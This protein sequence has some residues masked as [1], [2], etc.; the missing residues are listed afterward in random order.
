[1]DIQLNDSVT[2]NNDSEVKVAYSGNSLI[3]AGTE[4]PIEGFDLFADYESENDSSDSDFYDSFPARSTSGWS[5]SS[6]QSITIEFDQSIALDNGDDLFSLINNNSLN[7]YIDGEQLTSTDISN[8]YFG[9]P[10]YESSGGMT[11]DARCTTRR[12][13]V[14]LTDASMYDP[15]M[16]GSGM[17]DA[18]MYDDDAMDI[19]HDGW[20]DAYDPSMDGTVWLSPFSRSSSSMALSSRKAKP[21]LGWWARRFQRDSINCSRR[22]LM[23]TVYNDLR[24]R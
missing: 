12:W 3:I 11:D 8:I 9:N 20:V 6:G 10:S 5:E 7:V 22:S 15:A 24:Q 18:S 1:M 17:T 16:D 2:W 19:R 13:M 4:Q 23:S 21:S 14:P